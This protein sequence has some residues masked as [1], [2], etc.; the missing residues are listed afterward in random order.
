MNHEPRELPSI[1][2]PFSSLTL[3]QVQIHRWTW[4]VSV[5]EKQKVDLREII[6]AV[7]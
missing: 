3:A 4:V 6:R 1:E 2:S 7:A 5:N